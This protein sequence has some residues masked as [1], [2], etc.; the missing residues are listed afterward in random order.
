[1]DQ[2]EE[3]KKRIDI[4]DYIGNFV[5]LKKSGRNFTG[6]CPFHQEKTPSFEFEPLGR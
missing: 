3:I 4:V 5:T 6:L 1:M 2:I